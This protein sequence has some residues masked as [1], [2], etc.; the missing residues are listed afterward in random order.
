MIPAFNQLIPAV[1]HFFRK[2]VYIKDYV[3]TIEVICERVMGRISKRG[4]RKTMRNLYHHRATSTLRA[5]L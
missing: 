1:N 4:T 2:L 3:V 5:I